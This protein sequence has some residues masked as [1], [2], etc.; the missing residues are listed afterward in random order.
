M[1]WWVDVHRILSGDQ[2]MDYKREN[3]HIGEVKVV[4]KT[5]LDFFD[6]TRHIDELVLWLVSDQATDVLVPNEL[7]PFKVIFPVGE[8]GIAHFFK[9]AVHTWRHLHIIVWVKESEGGVRVKKHENDAVQTAFGEFCHKFEQI[10]FVHI[11]DEVATCVCIGL[12]A[13]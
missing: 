7:A 2:R 3:A 10:R 8:H 1:F 11:R 4:E 9:N 5:H 12:S 6:Q 13:D